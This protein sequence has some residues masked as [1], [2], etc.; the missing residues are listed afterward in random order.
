MFP[1]PILTYVKLVAI[2]LALLF[3]AYLGYN[4]EH[5]RFLAFKASIIEETRKKEIEQQAKT[6]EIRK[7]KDAQIQ[8][9]NNQ[10]ANAL[11]QLRNR[12][13]RSNQ[14]SSNGQVATGNDGS[15]LFYEDSVF[16]TRE[17]SR[18]DQIR[19]ALDACYKQ[20]DEVTK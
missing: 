9:I 11:I 20:Y 18:A 8:S 19:T 12:P 1:L 7:V 15:K 14:I 2:A 13:S 16:L 17:A 3:S 10:L 6:D 4:F 5:S